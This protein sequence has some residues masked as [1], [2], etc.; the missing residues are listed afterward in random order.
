[1]LYLL[2]AIGAIIAVLAAIPIT[3]IAVVSMASLREESLHSLGDKAP[4]AGERAAR[5]ILGF[6]T[7]NIGSLAPRRT[8]RSASIAD[9]EVRFTHA[10]RPMSDA[11]QFAAERQSQPDRLGSDQRQRAGV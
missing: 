7:A 1:V 11:G 2:I 6:H 3:V 5:R 8:T 9:P 10:R 4:G